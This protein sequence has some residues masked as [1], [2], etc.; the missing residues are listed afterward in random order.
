M[1]T[2]IGCDCGL[3]RGQG[4]LFCPVEVSSTEKNLLAELRYQL[5]SLMMRLE[6]KEEEPVAYS[7]AKSEGIC[8]SAQQDNE[9]SISEANTNTSHSNDQSEVSSKEH[10]V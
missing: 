6:A 9:L 3:G 4:T 10:K 1:T 7:S 5:N 2:N 8:Q